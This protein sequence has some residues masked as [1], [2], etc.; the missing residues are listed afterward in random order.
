GRLNSFIEKILQLNPPPVVTGKRLRI[1][2][3][4]QVKTQPPVFLLFVNSP[5][6]VAQSYL[7]FINNQLRK[8]FGF[9]GVP[10]V[11]SLKGKKVRVPAK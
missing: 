1:Y 2:Y 3:L 9:E 7:R 5:H 6:L 4:T 8:E 10:L 11:L